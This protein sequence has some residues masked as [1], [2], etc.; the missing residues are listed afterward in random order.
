MAVPARLFNQCQ[1][2]E[3][4]PSSRH[5]NLAARQFRLPGVDSWNTPA[6]VALRTGRGRQ[7]RSKYDDSWS[8]SPNRHPHDA[9][10]HYY[11][12][13]PECQGPC[14]SSILPVY[15]PNRSTVFRLPIHPNRYVIT[16]HPSIRTSWK[17]CSYWSTP[18]FQVFRSKAKRSLS[19]VK[20]DANSILVFCAIAIFSPF[21]LWSN[22]LDFRS[23]SQFSPGRWSWRTSLSSWYRWD[24]AGLILHQYEFL[25]PFTT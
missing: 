17:V 9:C 11:A 16:T 4:T 12:L 25:G 8:P 7:D 19:I 13:W 14:T 21:F 15:H 10:L 2:G 23:A 22:V 20:L 3:N 6:S 18:C 24:K 1:L 5:E